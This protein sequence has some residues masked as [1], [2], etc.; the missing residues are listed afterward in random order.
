MSGLYIRENLSYDVKKYEQNQKLL[1]M[2]KAFRKN[3]AL[4][5][6]TDGEYD[7]IMADTEN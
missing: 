2:L 3:I 5:D 7:T 4:Q 1:S 6:L